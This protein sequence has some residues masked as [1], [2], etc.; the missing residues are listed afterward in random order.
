MT[1]AHLEEI[2]NLQE[3]HEA[4]IKELE[5]QH[6]KDIEQA[7]EHAREQV[8]IELQVRSRAESKEFILLF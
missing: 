4:G 8:S 1:E 5:F 6:A 7:R 2:K 3:A